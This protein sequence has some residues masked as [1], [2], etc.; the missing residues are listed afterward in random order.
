[1]SGVLIEVSESS[2]ARFTNATAAILG[3]DLSSENQYEIHAVHQV[4]N[5]KKPK[6]R[7]QANNHDGH[8]ELALSLV[9]QSPR[10][11]PTTHRKIGS[12][13]VSLLFEQC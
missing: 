3:Q 2:L 4:A 6:I 8:K 9:L 7:I 10:T 11:L 12:G 5:A 1:M 13:T